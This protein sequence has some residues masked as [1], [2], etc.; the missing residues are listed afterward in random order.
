MNK[1]SQQIPKKNVIT[2]IIIMTLLMTAIVLTLIAQYRINDHREFQIKFAQNTTQNIALHLEKFIQTRQHYVQLF[3]RDHQASIKQLFDDPTN[4]ALLKQLKKLVAD[5]F[6]HYFSITLADQSGNTIID[7]FD[8]LVGEVCQQ[9]ISI[10]SKNHSQRP[11]IHPNQHTYHFDIMTKMSFGIFF[12]S[13]NAEL[14]ANILKNTQPKG[15]DLMLVHQT[16][17]LIE[18]TS[19]GS[20]NVITNRDSYLLT[21]QEQNNIL[22][23]T[24][25]KNTLWLLTD[26]VKPR[27]FKDYKYNIIKQMSLIFACFLVLSLIML[28]FALKV[29]TKELL[30]CIDV[31][32]HK[33]QQLSI[34][35]QQKN[36]LFSIIAHDLRNPF[37]PIISY[38]KNILDDFNSHSTENLLHKIKSINISAQ[39]VHELLETL[40]NWSRLQMEKVTIHKTSFCLNNLVNQ[41][42]ALLQNVAKAK[43]ITLNN[44]IDASLEIEADTSV[45]NTVLRNLINNAIKF[46]HENGEI[47]IT[48]KQQTS[49]WL[50]SV[51]D[52]GVGMTQHQIEA[53]I[54]NQTQSTDGTKNETGTGLGLSICLDLLKLHDSQLK[55]NS[56]P[57]Q[58][59]AFG[60]T[61][62]AATTNHA[63]TN[64]LPPVN[65]KLLVNILIVDD[66]M[67]NRV[68]IDS[69]IKNLG[70]NCDNVSNGQEALEALEAL[71]NKTYHLVFTDIEMPIMN[72]IELVRSIKSSPDFSNLPVIAIT[73]KAYE[74]IADAGFSDFMNKTI[75]ESQLEFMIEQYIKLA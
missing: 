30:H 75:A 36:K 20:R 39:Q 21:R 69:I 55:I 63:I 9:D 44:G 50:I 22:S 3:A 64:N 65:H 58:G 54:N 34:S 47:K 41:N 5:Y 53:I 59:S 42:I 57:D 14:L 23:K 19:E 71:K 15:H 6:P 60:F 38:S 27:L 46:S 74:E 25:I 11:S 8:G 35:N 2:V 70:Y 12:V 49:N 16:K 37:L 51:N 7:D 68:L 4:E 40:L 13:F 61:V 32:N 52:N 28:F 56:A 1:K 43:N 29:A 18:V 17:N 72:G 48:A 33:S 73:G 67:I 62:T 66:E 31:I 26:S 45:I 24:P 10:F